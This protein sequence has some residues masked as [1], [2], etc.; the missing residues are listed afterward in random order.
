MYF[1]IRPQLY[2]LIK[3]ESNHILLLKTNQLIYFAMKQISLL[4]YL[5]LLFILTTALTCTDHRD[6]PPA[7]RFRVKTVKYSE[8]KFVHTLTYDNLGRL[9]SY[10]G[11]TSDSFVDGSTFVG[12]SGTSDS[13]VIGILKLESRFSSS[14]SAKN[15]F[16]N[17][18]RISQMKVYRY[19]GSRPYPGDSTLNYTY[20]YSG[21]NTTPIARTRIRFI[22]GVIFANTSE[23]YS[24]TGGNATTINGR[25]YTYDTAPNPY[26]GLYG[27]I[28]YPELISPDAFNV[29]DR[30]SDSS[31]KIFNQNNCTNSAQLTYNSD[32]LV[33]KIAYTDGRSEE[34]TYETY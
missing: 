28:P 22:D 23:T 6:V 12:Y 16:D 31:V 1:L 34:F 19:Y 27:F 15:I 8:T 18:G 9:V 24:F 5:S 2:A 13:Y 25:T 33:T 32:G 21:N 29:S 30:F 7:A 14:S 26:K 17:Q 10:T 3:S 4:G 20:T 11:P